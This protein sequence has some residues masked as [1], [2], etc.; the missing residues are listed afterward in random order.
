ML[1]VNANEVLVV[2]L[3]SV[4]GVVVSIG[5]VVVVDSNGIVVVASSVPFRAK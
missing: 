4:D 5:V 2:V 1:V 3:V